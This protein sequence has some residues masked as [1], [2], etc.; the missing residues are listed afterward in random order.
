MSQWKG[1]V[2]GFTPCPVSGKLDLE[3]TYLNQFNGGQF[4]IFGTPADWFTAIR[5]DPGWQCCITWRNA[6]I[7]QTT[8]QWNKFDLVDG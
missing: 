1:W 5:R 2:N 7:T 3:T 4:A 8:F 6:A